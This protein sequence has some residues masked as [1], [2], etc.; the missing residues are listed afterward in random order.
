[1]GPVDLPAPLK[2]AEQSVGRRCVVLRPYEMMVVLK[3]DLE[4][5][6]VEAFIEKI[7]SMIQT[8]DG[9]VD[10]VTK[11]GRRRLAYEIKDQ[12]DGIYLIF[13]FHSNPDVP[14]ELDRQLKITDE[15]L[16]FMVIRTDE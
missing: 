1:M 12:K 11:W 4:S 7:S 14:K 15:V 2:G 16:R 10:E 3:A 9:V 5:E 13:N 8:R 6:A